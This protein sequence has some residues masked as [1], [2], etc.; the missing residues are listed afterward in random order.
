MQIK[1]NLQN[2]Q[3]L[4]KL[5]K[6]DEFSSVFSFRKR[7]SAHFLVFH[8]QPNQLKFCRLGLVVSKKVAK[9]AIDRNYMRRVL[10]ELYRQQASTQIS[11]DLVIRVQN[12]FASQN[13]SQVT[14]EFEGL[15]VKLQKKLHLLASVS[16]KTGD[17]K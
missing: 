12:A 13:F 9:R 2:H 3:R 14:Q 17:E 7:V 11:V 16:V 4:V 10:R 1:I 8:Y 15:M 5:T 6:T